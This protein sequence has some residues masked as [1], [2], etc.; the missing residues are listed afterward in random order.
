[1][2][3]KLGYVYLLKKKNKRARMFNFS[4]QHRSQS[5]SF[6]GD[7]EWYKVAEKTLAGAWS[8]NCNFFL[9]FHL[10]KEH[11]MI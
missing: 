4:L 7:C 8:F 5:K 3:K 9:K 10:L 2:D 6:M 1:M 11:R